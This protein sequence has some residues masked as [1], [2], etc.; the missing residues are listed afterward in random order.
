MIPA[1]LSISDHPPLAAKRLGEVIGAVEFPVGTAAPVVAAAAIEEL[2]ELALSGYDSEAS[3]ELDAADDAEVVAA[4][5]VPDDGGGAGAEEVGG[6]LAVVPALELEPELEL[7][8]PTGT[9]T[10]PCTLPAEFDDEVPAA[11]DLYV[12]RESPDAG[13]LMTPAMPDWQCDGVEQ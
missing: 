7:E 12:A 13:G 11:L 9:T 10:P 2:V 5:V 8:P 4:E 1:L 3:P 6:V